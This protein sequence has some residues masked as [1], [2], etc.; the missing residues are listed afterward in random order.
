[1]VSFYGMTVTV[2]VNRQPLTE[3]NDENSNETN[4]TSVTRYIISK[5]GDLFDLQVD[6]GN[7]AFMDC[8]GLACYYFVD[9]VK[10]DCFYRKLG[11]NQSTYLTGPSVCVNGNWS[12]QQLKF[13]DLHTSRYTA[14]H[15]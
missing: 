11:E 1:M 10:I 6:T 5:P 2:R 14:Q 9:G 8:T 7:A 3:Y 12:T 13:A 15:F 4:P